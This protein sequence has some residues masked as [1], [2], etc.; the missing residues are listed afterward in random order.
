MANKKLFPIPARDPVTWWHERKFIHTDGLT[1]LY[2]DNIDA[3]QI[4][5]ERLYK[6][7]TNE[8]CDDGEWIVK[9]FPVKI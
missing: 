3:A 8:E 9:N 5:K 1:V 4:W 6:K 7:K 2:E